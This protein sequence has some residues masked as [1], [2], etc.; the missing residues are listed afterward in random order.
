MV[1]ESSRGG[2]QASGQTTDTERRAAIWTR[3][4]LA[5]TG[6]VEGIFVAVSAL[7]WI[8]VSIGRALPAPVSQWQRRRLPD[9]RVDQG[10]AKSDMRREEVNNM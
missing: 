9:G 3:V 2:V 7:G 4:A 1:L 10:V 6:N 5:V 8:R